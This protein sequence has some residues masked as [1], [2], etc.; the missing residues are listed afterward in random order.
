[1]VN[2]DKLKTKL[3]DSGKKTGFVAEK[4]GITREGFHKKMTGKSQFNILEV[5]VLCEQLNITD[6]EEFKDIFLS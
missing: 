1:M 6:A 5:K 4:L 3:V 2:L